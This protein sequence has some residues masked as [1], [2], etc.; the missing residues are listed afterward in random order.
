MFISCAFPNKD[1]GMLTI[2]GHNALI[3]EQIET[4]LGLAWAS[5]RDANQW[6]ARWRIC[7]VTFWQWNHEG[8]WS[9]YMSPL[10]DM[11]S[12]KYC[13]WTRASIQKYCAHDSWVIVMR[14][15][16]KTGLTYTN[17]FRKNMRLKQI[18]FE[19]FH[20]CK[21]YWRWLCYLLAPTGAHKET[22]K[23]TKQRNLKLTP[24]N[25]QHSAQHVSHVGTYPVYIAN[26][27][28]LAALALQLIWKGILRY[29]R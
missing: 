21:W 27:S 13:L 29:G 4:G 8:S 5:D 12:Q 14:F 22:K 9:E 20:Y 25:A 26:V 16:Y 18:L 17:I 2:R 6:T 28:D 24:K 11:L 19:L 15:N 3:W 10:V 1:S 7:A 23:H